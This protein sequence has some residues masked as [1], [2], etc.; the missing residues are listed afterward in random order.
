MQKEEI[1]SEEIIAKAMEVV[2]NGKFIGEFS[3]SE[4]K[5]LEEHNRPLYAVCKMSKEAK[6]KDLENR[7]GGDEYER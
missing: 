6:A 5:W 4:E 2:N 1:N 3:E 7:R